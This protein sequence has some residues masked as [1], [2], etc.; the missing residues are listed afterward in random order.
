MKFTTDSNMNPSY[1][2]NF[3]KGDDFITFR[4]KLKF[5]NLE[6]QKQKNFDD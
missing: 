6:K 1:L 5:L 3:K 2:A 4:D